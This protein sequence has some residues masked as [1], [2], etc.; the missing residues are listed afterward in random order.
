MPTLTVDLGSVTEF[1]T[2]QLFRVDSSR[3]LLLA[4]R[5]GFGARGGAAQ[6]P[7]GSPAFRYKIET[8]ADGE[9]YTTMLR[10]QHATKATPFDLAFKAPVTAL[11]LRVRFHYAGKAAAPRFRIKELEPLGG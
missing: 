10:N 2:E 9:T 5:G 4:G 6:P 1:A 11:Y 3:I 7:T 8:S